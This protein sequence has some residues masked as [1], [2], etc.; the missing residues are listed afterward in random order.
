MEESKDNQESKLINWRS[1]VIGSLTTFIGITIALVGSYFRLDTDYGLATLILAILLLGQIIGGFVTAYIHKP[2]YRIGVT[3]GALAA[4]VGIIIFLLF[5]S[6]IGLILG[7]KNN[8][9]HYLAYMLSYIFI[10]MLLGVF[11]AFI[12]TS[13]KKLK[14]KINNRQIKA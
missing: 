13:T 12:G 8:M 11:G 5:I 9:L 6:L 10:I 7:A 1:I 2:K 3:R 4:L 14:K